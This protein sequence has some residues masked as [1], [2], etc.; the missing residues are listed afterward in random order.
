MVQPGGHIS[1]SKPAEIFHSFSQ[2]LAS[3]LWNK[4]KARQIGLDEVF[5]KGQPLRELLQR[6]GVKGQSPVRK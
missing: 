2:S 3:N 6:T 5:G 1:G 4:G